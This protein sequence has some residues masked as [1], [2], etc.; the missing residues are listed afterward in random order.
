MNISVVLIGG[1]GNRLFQIANALRL[2][3]LYKC[4]LTFYKIIANQTDVNKLRFL[5]LRCSDFDEFGGHELSKKE[6]L[7]HTM[8][9][10]FP[11]FDW[12]N[13]TTDLNNLLTN[14][15]L[16]LENSLDKLGNG[17]NSIVIGYFFPYSFIK[18]QISTIKSNLNPS[19]F[20]Y[21]N[22]N[23]SELNKFRILGIHLRLGIDTDN[24]DA[25]I[26]PNCFYEQV[27]NDLEGHYDKVYVIS[28]NVEKA[29]NFIKTFKID[30]EI[31]FIDNEPMYVDMLILSKCAYLAIAPSTL[32]AWASYLSK[33]DQIYVPKIWLEHHWTEDIPEKWI[34]L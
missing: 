12:H 7:P 19:I 23:Y 34:L 20:H 24:T 6:G 13:E 32:S 28:D 21:I 15:Q 9:E 3:R 30:K 27:L 26:V 10:I 31:K 11:L 22:I 1:F 33:S 29:K 14:N 5:V 18:E 25:I 2:Q 16:V 4:N 17:M 8:N